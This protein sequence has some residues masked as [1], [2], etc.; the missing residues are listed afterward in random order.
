MSWPRTL[1]WVRARLINLV[2]GHHDRHVGRL[3]VVDGFHGLRH[4]AV[5]GRDHKDRNVG[6]F[7]ATGTHGG[8]GFVAW[9]IEERDLTRFAFEIDGHLVCTDTLGNAAGLTCDDVGTTD[10]V[11][12]SGLTMIDMAHHSD[13]RR[14]RLQIFIFLKFFFVQIDV[15]LLQ[16]FLVF[17]F[18][19]HD[20]DVPAD[21]LTEDLEGGFVQ[22]LGCRSHLTKVEQYGD[23]CR[24][25]DVDL[26]GQIGKGCALTQTNGLTVAGR[27][28]HAADDRGLHLL[29][30]LT[31]CQTVL[32]SL[33]GLAALTTERACGTAT[34]ATAAACRTVARSAVAALEAATIGIGAATET[35]ATTCRTLAAALTRTML[36]PLPRLRTGALARTTT[37]ASTLAAALTRAAAA[38]TFAVVIVVGVRTVHRMRTRNVTRSRGMHALLAAERIVTRTWARSVRLRTIG[39]IVAIAALRSIGIVIVA[40]CARSRNRS[41]LAALTAFALR[42]RSVAVGAI[43]M[44]A[45]ITRTRHALAGLRG[46]GLGCCRTCRLWSGRLCRGCRGSSRSGTRRRSRRSCRGSRLLGRDRRLLG[47]G[48][49]ALRVGSESIPQLTGNRRF[50]GRRC[51]LH[52]FAHRLKFVQNS[53]AVNAKFLGKFIYACFRHSIS[54]IL[55]R[56]HTSATATDSRRACS[57]SSC[58]HVRDTSSFPWA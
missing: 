10:G 43:A 22:G 11:K 20:L 42:T 40:L 25:I 29:E 53:L 47:F 24:R 5:I 44:L 19:G 55:G 35:V 1:F 27:N 54:P 9:G 12:Q 26:L 2:D 33:R 8:E 17:L 37:E 45:G 56:A 18:G 36:A 6:E 21:F 39:G 49:V 3:S 46:F 4:H 58:N 31:L 30:F 13:D 57:F 48:C 51:G 28:T 14:T 23:Q 34:T 41:R 32:T 38:T 16:Q 52:K 15:E 50:N 7:G